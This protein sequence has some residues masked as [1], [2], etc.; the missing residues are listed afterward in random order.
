[1]STNGHHSVPPTGE[2]VHLS[3]PSLV[4]IACASGIALVLIGLMLGWGF[5]I[6]GGAIAILALRRWIGETRAD[7]S[8]LPPGA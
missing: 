8:Q 5:T 4:P 6:A 1:M 7:V 2:E 3:G